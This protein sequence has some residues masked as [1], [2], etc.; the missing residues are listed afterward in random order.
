MI[1][2]E[3]IRELI[4][5]KPFQ[6]FRLL[7]SDGSSHNVP[8]SEFAWVFGSRVFVGVASRSATEADGLVKQLSLLH[9]S[10]IEELPRAKS[11]KRRS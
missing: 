1:T 2:A 11:K 7:L 6:A 9:I 4:N 5:A 8:H 3:H 10:R